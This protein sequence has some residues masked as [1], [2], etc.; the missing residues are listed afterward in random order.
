[1][2]ANGVAM[3][4]GS[5]QHCCHMNARFRDYS[6]AITRTMAEHF[7]GN[8]QVVGW[9][10]DNELHCHFAEC[11]CG[12]CQTAFRR[13]LRRKFAGDI[14]AL[15]RAWGTQ[16]WSQTYLRFEDIDTPRADKLFPLPHRRRGALPARPGRD[17]AR[18]EP[19]VVG[20]P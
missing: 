14:G 19:E 5:R 7:R 6:R 2:N 4:H 17:P 10:T 16:F 15:N 8:P 13:F 3:A 20:H 11:H 9:Q 18:G 12:S 1:V